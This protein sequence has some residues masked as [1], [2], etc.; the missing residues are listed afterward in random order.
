MPAHRC[1]PQSLCLLLLL[2]LAGCGSRAAGDQC[3]PDSV[4]ANVL[5]LAH[6]WYLWSS[7]LPATINLG[8]Y[9]GQ[10]TQVL[11]DAL[12]AQPRAEGKD[13]HFSYMTTQSANATFFEDGQNLGFGFGLLQRGS[14][15]F[16][17]QVFP[18]SAVSSAGLAR[19]D[20][21]LAIAAS[22]PALDA[23][24][25]QVPA[26]L[27]ADGLA[28]ALSSSVSQTTRFF[29]V[30]KADG[31]TPPAFSMT[32]SVYSLEPVPGAA[33]PII[34]STGGHTV[35][36]L[37][38]RTFILPAEA[39][40]RTAF[41]AFRAA[42]V[43]DVV[44]DLRYDGGGRLSTA[45]VLANLLGS[46]RSSSDVMYSMTFNADHRGY[47]GPTYFGA[48]ANALA[49]GKVAFIVDEGSASASE[50]VI[51]ALQPYFTEAG[52]LPRLAVVGSRTYGKPVGQFGFADPSCDWL[53]MLISFQIVNA[54]GTGGYFQGLPDAGFK[55]ASC[56]AADDLGHA[57]GDASE[58][59]TGAALQ[60]I[61]GGTCPAGPIAAM[62]P[63]LQ[64]RRAEAARAFEARRPAPTLAQRHV[65]G[66]F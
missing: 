53:L 1:A 23:P 9:A 44:V 49:P 8:D 7:E 25:S 4:N 63:V 34:L 51:N 59:S 20:E 21:L 22:A 32:N 11:L 54:D 15:L 66:L 27:A 62:T 37:R 3:S 65:P 38:L 5:S 45:V 12:T 50:L 60:W 55:G 43:T 47:L 64:A 16:V 24:A 13:R 35:G 10:P 58:A 42:G 19:G 46:G 41:G 36:Y 33:T 40:L 30:R 26:I 61:L 14:Q 6:N 39:L 2:H 57:L 17:G 28:T 18:G 56:A 52:T 29:R 31:S 48:E